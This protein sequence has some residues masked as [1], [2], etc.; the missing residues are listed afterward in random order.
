MDDPCVIAR[1][2]LSEFLQAG[3]DFSAGELTQTVLLRGGTERYSSEVLI[4]DR[5]QVLVK[6]G[7]LKYLDE[8]NVYAVMFGF[9]QQLVAKEIIIKYFLTEKD[10]Y[11][12]DELMPLILEKV[13]IFDTLELS[14]AIEKIFEQM[15]MVG[16]LR[17]DPRT[18]VASFV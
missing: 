18:G 17:F 9:G 8:Q 3:N 15:T 2:T 6:T 4:Y 7:R 1:R 10:E 5:L 16:C 14:Q 13:K 12:L 11:S